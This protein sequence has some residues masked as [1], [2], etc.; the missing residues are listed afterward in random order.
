MFSFFIS[1]IFQE[2]DWEILRVAAKIFRH[3]LFLFEKRWREK[4]HHKW[5]CFG[6]GGARLKP[7]ACLRRFAQTHECKV[8]LNVNWVLKRFYDLDN[9]AFFTKRMHLCKAKKNWE[10]FQSFQNNRKHDNSF[11]FF[12]IE[13]AKGCETLL[14]TR[15]EWNDAHHFNCPPIR[16]HCVWSESSTKSSSL[17]N[18]KLQKALSFQKLKTIK[19]FKR[20]KA[21]D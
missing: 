4:R 19:N 11:E 15:K 12:L 16:P 8:R 13:L 10:S 7:H 3:R 9:L 17:K 20:L 21:L 2:L 18:F 5:L 1:Y 6:F 14:Q